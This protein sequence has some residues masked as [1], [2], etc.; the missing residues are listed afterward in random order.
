MNDSSDDVE[1]LLV[2]DSEDDVELALRAFKLANLAKTIHVARDGA[3]ALDFLFCQGEFANRK[4]HKSPKLVLLDYKLPKIDG[5]EV[6]RRMK[7]DE[8]T[9][10]IPVVMLT[11]SKEQ[12]DV[13]ES[14]QLGVNAY[15]VKPVNFEEFTEAIQKLG[16]FWLLLNQAPTIEGR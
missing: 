7:T 9:R 8:R 13:M 12:K 3:A 11:S 14:Y 10:V 15:I 1:I 2:E 4:M 6:L 16:W 5:P